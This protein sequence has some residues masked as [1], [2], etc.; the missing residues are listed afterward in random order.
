MKR[1]AAACEGLIFVSETDAP[2][3][4]V[5]FP[6]HIEFS[7][8]GVLKF[9]DR[10]EEEPI[11]TVNYEEFF[12]RLAKPEEWHSEQE[13]EIAR[14]FGLLRDVLENEFEDLRVY[15]VGEIRVDILIIGRTRGGTIAGVR[16]RAVET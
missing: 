15:R 14:G 10:S 9:L 4:P 12:D 16:T 2:V 11:Q 3:E 6:R 5:K 13:K 8:I 7:A 1:L